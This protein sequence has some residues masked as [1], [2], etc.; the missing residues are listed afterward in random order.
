[1]NHDPT[2]GAAF[3]ATDDKGNETM[4]EEIRKKVSD[5]ADEDTNEESQKKIDNEAQDEDT[6][7]N[8]ERHVDLWWL[9]I[10][11]VIALVLGGI[12]VYWE[13]TGKSRD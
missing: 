8:T 5:H 11:L 13:K 9:W 7:M 12:V 2:P 3:I 4:M 6:E 10:L 1:M